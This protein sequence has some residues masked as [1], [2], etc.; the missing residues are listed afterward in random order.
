MYKASVRV[1]RNK[2]TRKREIET[3]EEKDSTKT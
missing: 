2:L 1:S 3:I